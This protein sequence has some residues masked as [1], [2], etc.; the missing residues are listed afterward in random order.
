MRLARDEFAN[1]SQNIVKFRKICYSFANCEFFFCEM[2]LRTGQTGC[3]PLIPH[4]T[5]LTPRPSRPTSHPS[6]LTSHRVSVICVT[7]R[8]DKTSMRKSH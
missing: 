2:G 6:P 8:L 7:I 1:R 5:P 3:S 4:P